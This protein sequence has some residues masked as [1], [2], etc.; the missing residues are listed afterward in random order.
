MHTE[1]NVDHDVVFNPMMQGMTCFANSVD[2]SR[3]NMAAKYL[4]QTVPCKN[5]ENPYAIT[6]DAYTIAKT[7]DHFKMY[8]DEDVYI[9]FHKYETMV[10]FKKESLEL[11][12]FYLPK[13][14]DAANCSYELYYISPNKNIKKGELIY[15]YA[16][17]DV[18]NSVPKIGYRAN[19]AYT[20][21]FGF[22]TEDSYV[23]S[24][25]FSKKM[26]IVNHEKIFIP[27][28]HQLKYFKRFKN[29]IPE[30]GDKVMVRDGIIA[31]QPV[32]N[33]KNLYTITANMTEKESQI[34]SK[35]IKPKNNGT[36]VGVKIHKFSKNDEKLEIEKLSNSLLYDEL[37][38]KYQKKY[39]QVKNDILEGLSSEIGDIEVVNKLVSGIMDTHMFITKLSKTSI[40]NKFKQ[41]IEEV[42]LKE[43][44]YL[45]ELDI[46]S[47]KK[48][49]GGDKITTMYA[50]KGT[51]GLII[52][53]ELMPKDSQGNTYDVISNP[54]SI[55]GRNNWGVIF[56]TSLAKIIEDIQKDIAD[57]NKSDAIKKLNF[58]I[59]N[60]SKVET[61]DIVEDLEK[62]LTDIETN[63]SKWNQFRENVLENGLY[64]IGRS[65]SNFSYEKYVHDFIWKYEVEFGINI[66]RKSKIIYK[67]EL[68]DWLRNIGLDSGVFDIPENDT[69]VDVFQGYNYIMKLYHV[70][71]SKYNMS[72][73]SGKYSYAGQPVKG[74][75]NQGG[76]HASW[77]TT[78]A[79]LSAGATEIM[80]ELYTVKSDCLDD[81]EDFIT[82]MIS[83]EYILK[84]KYYSKTKSIIDINLKMLGLS[85]E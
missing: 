30:I 11:V 21:F 7:N 70:S 5:A 62:N 50:G 56:E 1:N 25:S 26:R 53:D 44:D 40:T 8:A 33:D 81:K 36:V 69:T 16:P 66:S 85:F 78:G 68:L 83:G 13:F 29:F 58:C 3:L 27:I 67:K 4:N 82:K 22:T 18:E 79:L 45:V 49:Q 37:E 59:E 17:I 42:D 43:V 65:F 84:N 63:T 47:S 12:T 74:R 15:S 61:P 34:F 6:V 10:I 41:M 54:I 32:E 31:Y 72:H 38:E 60:F 35:I 75:K 14:Q 64:F 48:T 20:P 39:E 76:T 55:F 80:K 71:D 77:Q 19:I 2:S 23:I 57:N 46:A 52:P 9:V 24:E 51:I 73:I 28:T